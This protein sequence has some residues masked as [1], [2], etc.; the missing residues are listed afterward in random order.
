MMPLTIAALLAAATLQVGAG[1]PPD[2]ATL[3]PWLRERIAAFEAAPVTNPPRSVVRYVYRDATVYLIPARC[4]DI[5]SQLLDADGERLC[6]PDGGITG[7]GDGRCADFHREA[8]GRTP[9]W[10][11]ARE[12]TPPP[13]R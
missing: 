6:A 2:T 8:R 12:R 4:C 3:P 9:V 11:D 5:P 1:E 7:R 10:R 13:K